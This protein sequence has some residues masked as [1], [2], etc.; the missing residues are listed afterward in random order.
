VH[1]S[2]PRS[3]PGALVARVA[4]IVLVVVALSAYDWPQW[5]LNPQHSGSNTQETVISASNVSNL[6]QIYRVTIPGDADGAPAYLS[7][8]NTANGVKNLLFVTTTDGHIAALDSQTGAVVWS[9][10]YGPGGCTINNTGPSFPCYTT[11]SPAVDPNRLYVYSYGLEG[12]VHKYQVSDG[13]EINTGGWPELATLKPWDEKQSPA[14]SIATAASGVSYLYVTNGGYPGDGG[15]YQGHLTAINLS[16]GVQQVFNALCS[17]QTV[18][19]TATSPDCP[20][21]QA[22]IWARPGVIYDP[23]TDKIYMATGNG[24]YDPANHHW[25]DTV[26]ALNPDGT[27]V[28]GNPLD[29]YTPDNYVY[30]DGAD[31][32]LGSTAPAILPNT[33]KYPHLAVQGGKDGVL[34]LLNLDDL[35]G[36]GGPGFTGGEVFT[37]TVPQGNEILTQPAVWVNPA[38]DSTWVFVANDNGLSGLQLT[39]DGGDNPRLVSQWTIGNGGTSPIVANGVLYYVATGNIWGINPVTHAQLW[40]DT[41]I[42]S[43]HWSTPIV[44]N[45]VLYITD[46]NSSLSAYALNG[47]AP[48]PTS[49]ATSTSGSGS[50][51]TPTSTP[52]PT[53]TATSTSDSGSTATPTS[54]PSP[55]PTATST[56]GSGST[57]TPTSTPT[58]TNTPTSNPATSYSLWNDSTLPKTVDSGDS[59]AVE[60]GVKFRADVDGYITGLRYYKASTNTGT[61]TGHLWANDGTL[62]ASLTFSGETASGWQTASFAAPIPTIANTVYV[63]SYHTDAGHISFDRHY[64]NT[65]YHNAPLYAFASSEVASGNGVYHYGASAFPNQT[66]QASN[67]WVDVIFSTSAPP[68]PLSNVTYLPFVVRAN[69]D[70][71]I[72]YAD[73]APSTPTWVWRW[74]WLWSWVCIQYPR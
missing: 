34:R 43:I 66:Y 33:S 50:T 74:C 51:A 36:H 38:D 2:G 28:G 13:H 72:A 29:T 65:G 44:A 24:T 7:G 60:L 73:P 6:Q 42:G 30:L 41:Q 1:Q 35:S 11:S 4:L 67:Y 14:L 61:H 18:H 40:H 19:F 31:L 26:F 48:T 68:T 20:E 46:Y 70:S 17:N 23:D 63:A 16:T 49:T 5:G 10:Q 3:Q 32:D 15:D 27:G 37:M 8:V 45:G 57:A 59:N 56:S 9:H 22:A 52:S 62:L 55:T 54:T 53:P 71:V 64:F 58:S 39:V 47:I 21:V 25:G 69:G 12:Y